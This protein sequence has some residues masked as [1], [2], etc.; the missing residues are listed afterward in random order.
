MQK[1]DSGEK[2]NLKK[3]VN[4]VQHTGLVFVA[5]GISVEMLIGQ[6]ELREARNFM[7]CYLYYRCKGAHLHR[8]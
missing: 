7:E 6:L 5:N 2:L 8:A 3:T 4:L 1:R